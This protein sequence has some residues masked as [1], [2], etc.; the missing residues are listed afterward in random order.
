MS[1]TT[2][3]RLVLD[4]FLWIDTKKEGLYEIS[5]V[6]LSTL[7]ALLIEQ[8]PVCSLLGMM[9]HSPHPLTEQEL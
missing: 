1:K 5:Y 9:E 2:T 6:L 4:V 3:S 8:V 7:S